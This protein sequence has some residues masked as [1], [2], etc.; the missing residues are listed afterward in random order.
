MLQQFSGV[1]VLFMSEACEM[2][3]V[4]FLECSFVEANVVLGTSAAL[5]PD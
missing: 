2:V 5:G 3:C 4:A 1:L